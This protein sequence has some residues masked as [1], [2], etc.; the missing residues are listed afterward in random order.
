MKVGDRVTFKGRVGTVKGFMPA[1]MTDVLFDDVGR[2]ER[3]HESL[4]QGQARKNRSKSRGPG[5]VDVMS[6]KPIM[7]TPTDLSTASNAPEGLSTWA[8]V[9][10]GVVVVGVVIGLA[11]AL[12]R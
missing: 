4:L 8:L 2:V 9:A 12:R 6:A 1:G 11:W 10:G 3:R 5:L 7:A